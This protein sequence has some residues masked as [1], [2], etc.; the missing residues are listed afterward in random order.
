M[1]WS[2]CSSCGCCL[3][4]ATTFHYIATCITAGLSPYSQQQQWRWRRKQ[5]QQ[6]QQQRWRRWRRNQQ[7]EQ[8]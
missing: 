1:E 7:Q 6:Q 2:E 8:W 3:S 5:Q 4:L